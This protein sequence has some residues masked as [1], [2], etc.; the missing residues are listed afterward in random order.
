MMARYS[1]L[2]SHDAQGVTVFRSRTEAAQE[3]PRTQGG[4]WAR[5][6]ATRSQYRDA[7]S[8]LPRRW[9][10]NLLEAGDTSECPESKAEIIR[11]VPRRMREET[12]RVIQNQRRRH[13]QEFVA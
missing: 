5:I 11:F 2:N 6:Q 8:T 3:P 13:V 7:S 12:V 9:G 4:S 1:G 10:A